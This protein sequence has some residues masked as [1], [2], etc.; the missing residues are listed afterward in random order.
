M[1]ASES[2][3]PVIRMRGVRKT[4]GDLVVLDDLD[5]EVPRG[6]KLALIGPGGSGKSTILR[7]LM[8]LE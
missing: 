4:Y 6:Q 5:L 2:R 8:A 1:V 3:E 7:I